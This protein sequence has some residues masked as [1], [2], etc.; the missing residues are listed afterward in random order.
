MALGVAGCSTPTPTSGS[1]TAAAGSASAELRAPASASASAVPATTSSSAPAVTSAAPPPEDWAKVVAVCP[2]AMFVSEILAGDYGPAG[3]PTTHY[4]QLAADGRVAFAS[5][6]SAT[7]R[8]SLAEKVKTWLKPG[9]GGSTGRWHLE[10]GNVVGTYEGVDGSRTRNFEL[11]I[12]KAP[13]TAR[14]P[15]TPDKPLRITCVP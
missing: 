15:G 9:K 5:V 11:A 12:A 6:Q 4:Y 8:K 13:F 1:S 3:E 10:A 2:S 14:D 7:D